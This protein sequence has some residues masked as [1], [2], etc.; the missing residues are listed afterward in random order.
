MST[1]SIEKAKGVKDI[2]PP[3]EPYWDFVEEAAKKTARDFDFFRISTPIFE[4]TELF[5]R[6]V[7][8]HTDIVSKEMY[9]FKTKGDDALTLRPEGTAPVMRAY[10][11]NGMKS[12]AQ[13]VKLFYLEP[14][15]R[16]E[17]P[18]HL[19]QRQFYQVGFETLGFGG[20]VIDAELIQAATHIL[21]RVGVEGFEFQV[22]SL[23]DSLCR[24][25]YMKRLQEYVKDNK[26]SLCPDCQES[27]AHRPLNMFECEEEKCAR[28]ARMAPKMIDEL[29]EPCHSHFR[30]LLEMLDEI[31]APYTL[32]PF[33]V[34]G[35]DYYT[36]TVF[37][38]WLSLEGEPSGMRALGGGGRYDELAGELGGGEIPGSGF[39]LGVERLIRVIKNQ[40]LVPPQH[41][42]REKLLFLAQLGFAARKRSLR[43]SSELMREG[44]KVSAAF[45][46]ESLSS[47]LRIADKLDVEYALILGEKELFDKSI[48]LRNMKTGNQEI[49]EMR[50]LV[51]EL[52]NRLNPISAKMFGLPS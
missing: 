47:Q 27:M 9:S 22:N 39:A 3:D 51:P 46:R 8:K 42:D 49:L 45:S 24:P 16:H 23:G 52:K 38:I 28:I 30:E 11:E 12:L 13:P 15:F 19:R 25:A 31:E 37:E 10:I 21:R 40:G 41:N 6:G 14:F 29:C 44:I 43:L 36:R 4:K 5:L 34:R 35:L 20:S 33:I 26:R 50:N 2:L 1:N 7:G 48:I 17:R 18:Q 32:N